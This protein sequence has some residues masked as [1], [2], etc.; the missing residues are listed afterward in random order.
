MKLIAL[1]FMLAVNVQ[2]QSIEQTADCTTAPGCRIVTDPI[3][4]A[5]PGVDRCDLW[6][7]GNLLPSTLYYGGVILPDGELPIMVGCLWNVVIPDGETWWLAADWVRPDWQY[8]PSSEFLII[9][10]KKGWVT[11]PPSLQRPTHLRLSSYGT[12]LDLLPL[13]IAPL[14][15]RSYM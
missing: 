7:G 2:A 6:R 15:Y 10:S 8:S 1:A 12:Y 9:T 13:G 5:V 3:E 14:F 4:K 11:P